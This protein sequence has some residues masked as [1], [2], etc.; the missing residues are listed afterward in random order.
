MVCEPTI[1]MLPHKTQRNWGRNSMRSPE[2]PLYVVDDIPYEV[3][4]PN[5]VVTV[6]DIAEM[7]VDRDGTAYGSRGANGVVIIRT[8][9]G[10][11]K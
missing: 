3:S 7:K 11:V 9:K 8:L 1:V 10:N 4:N 6:E 2:P 5:D